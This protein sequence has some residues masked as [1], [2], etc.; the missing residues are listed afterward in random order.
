MAA[1]LESGAEFGAFPALAALSRDPDLARL[2]AVWP[3]LPIE[4]KRA[5]QSL[6]EVAPGP[7]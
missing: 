3:D 5:I 4:V 1:E 6:V 7:V 2:V